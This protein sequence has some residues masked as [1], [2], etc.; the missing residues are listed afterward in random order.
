MLAT[1]A[2]AKTPRST[3]RCSSTS[4]HLHFTLTNSSLLDLAECWFVRVTNRTVIEPENDMREW[5]SQWSNF[6]AVHLDQ[7]RRRHIRDPTSTLRSRIVPVT[8]A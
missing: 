2:T 8:G 6:Q 4:F 3:S 1:R 5:I 7:G